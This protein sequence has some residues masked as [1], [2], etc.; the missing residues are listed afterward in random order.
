MAVAKA[1]FSR[2]FRRFIGSYSSAWR[3]RINHTAMPAAVGNRPA[4]A[5]SFVQSRAAK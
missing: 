2:K 4:P 5:R 3:D 1:A